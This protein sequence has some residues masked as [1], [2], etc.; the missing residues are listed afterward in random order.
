LDSKHHY[1]SSSPSEKD[2]VP[3]KEDKGQTTEWRATEQSTPKSSSQQ[4][5]QQQQQPQP[6]PQQYETR[7]QPTFVWGIL[8]VL[9][10]VKRRQMIRETYLRYY[11][12]L[13]DNDRICSL[14][15][16]VRKRIPYENCQVA[17]VF[18]VAGNPQGP[19]ELVHPNASFPMTIHDSNFTTKEEDVV[20]L[21]IKE[22]ME[23]GK[24]QTWF[25][26][27]SMVVK[28]YPSFDYVSKVDS[29]TLV[30]LPNFLE[31]AHLSLPKERPVRRVYGGVQFFNTSCDINEEN[32]P[33]PCPLPLLGDMYMSGSFYWMSADL[34]AFVASDAVDRAKLTIRHEDVDMGNFVFSHPQKIN[35]IN[36]HRK[37]VLMTRLMTLDW[38]YHTEANFKGILWGHSESG[39]WPGPFF[40]A[41]RNYR[42]LWQQFQGWSLPGK[43]RKVGVI[44]IRV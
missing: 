44:M 15:D 26:Y 7:N 1:Q 37:Q 3:P 35:A 23:D 40:K 22:N 36:V 24:S 6:Q 4:Q 34:A 41:E 33:H 32:H 12:D 11:K 30:F 38:E 21:N 9:G 16:I 5:Q 13:G 19:T 29:D 2:A 25:K 20:I 17:Y 27:A 14:N 28:D 8:S 39:F 18:V 42:K 10:D 31:F 43:K